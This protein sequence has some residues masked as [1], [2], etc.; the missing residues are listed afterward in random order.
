MLVTAYLC[1]PVLLSIT[2]ALIAFALRSSKQL[3]TGAAVIEKI[4]AEVTFLR[5]CVNG[6]VFKSAP[7]AQSA[8]LRT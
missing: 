4:A 1:F 8:P 6:E 2:H 5:M 3:H 7:A